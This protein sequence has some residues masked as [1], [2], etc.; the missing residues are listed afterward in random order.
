MASLRDVFAPPHAGV[1]IPLP[2]G[3]ASRNELLSIERRPSSSRSD[4]T[5]GT[6][7][8]LLR[9]SQLFSP[10][11]PVEFVR[12]DEVAACLVLGDCAAKCYD[13]SWA[14]DKV[15]C[16]L[17]PV[18]AVTLLQSHPGETRDSWELPGVSSGGELLRASQASGLCTTRD[19]QAVCAIDK[20]RIVVFDPHTG[21]ADPRSA[22]I[23]IA[24]LQHRDL[25]GIAELACGALAVT[26][27]LHKT[28]TI[29]ERSSGSVLSVTPGI[30]GATGAAEV[31][32]NVVAVSCRDVGVALCSVMDSGRRVAVER[33]DDPSVSYRQGT[34]VLPGAPSGDP[35]LCVACKSAGQ[36]GLQQYRSWKS[37]TGFP[38]KVSAACPS[39]NRRSVRESPLS[40][41][42]SSPSPCRTAARA[43]FSRAIGS[44]KPCSSPNCHAG[45]PFG[46]IRSS[47]L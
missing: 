2:D 22:V 41:V 27:F 12:R 18:F 25:Y 44:R 11:I 34:C 31:A 1:Y 26:C 28:L 29:V 45:V 16:C 30:S 40:V 14:G 19:G 13:A 21:V 7:L 3:A 37:P 10:A 39:E 32:P 47:C 35:V 8:L 4:R 17:P 42:A 5:A 6:A 23:K 46:L 36:D 33:F 43:V 20:S 24:A 38:R 15:M 9:L